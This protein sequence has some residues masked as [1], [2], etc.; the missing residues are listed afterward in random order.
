M[1]T[2][3]RQYPVARVMEGFTFNESEGKGLFGLGGELVIQPEYQRHYIYGDGARDVAVI[4]SLLSGYPLGLIYFAA[5]G[6]ATGPRLEVLDGQQRITS[7]GRF[8][9]DGFAIDRDG[10]RQYFTSLTPEER[11]RIL[12]A[13]LLVYECSG[14]EKEIKEWFSTINITGVPLNDQE[15]RNAI[16]SGPFVTA[17]KAVLS[18]SR[19]TLQQ[20]WGHYVRGDIRRQDVLATALAW[21]A[22]A[23][24]TSVDAYMAARRNNA[25]AAAD[26]VAY[27]SSVV[28]W[29]ET[30]FGA[31]GPLARGL[32]WGRLY[33]A[34]KDTAYRPAHL[35]ERLA[36]LLADEAVTAKKGAYEY[37]LSDETQPRLLAVR[38]FDER[39]KRAAYAAQTKAAEQAGVSNCPLC[40]TGHPATATRVYAL[41]EME[42]DHVTAWT[43]GG[44]TTAANCQM[45]CVT[46]NRAKGNR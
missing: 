3:L 46:H 33:E 39:T 19:H 18:N 14:T 20:K 38:V 11:E 31:P 45:L 15:L 44:D 17:A 21:A 35:A 30:L 26:L 22:H 6:A 32:D 36:A 29:A 12:S 13:T 5:T 40:A 9:A 42:A 4:D 34:H 25:A 10:R 23:E 27:F 24:N 41:K 28:D 7:I 8:V 43:N 16:Y 1:I 37:L 2:E